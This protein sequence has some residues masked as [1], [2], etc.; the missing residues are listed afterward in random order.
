MPSLASFAARQARHSKNAVATAT[1]EHG[2]SG[3][4]PSN[5]KVYESI[6]LRESYRDGSHVCKGN[7]ANLTPCDPQEIAAMELAL[8]CK[9]NLAAGCN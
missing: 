6:Y 7:T 4:L 2:Y 5:G 3:R 1:T 9:N 8:R